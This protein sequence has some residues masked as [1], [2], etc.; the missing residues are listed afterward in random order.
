MGYQKGLYACA[1]FFPIFILCI[2]FAV[3]SVYPFGDRS[4]LVVDG[5]H[6]YMT[7]FIELLHQLKSGSSWTHA[8]HAMGYN[9][10]SVFC[11][12][13]SSPFTIIVLLLNQFL[14]INEALTIVILIKVGISGIAMTWYAGRTI[15]DH[16]GKVLCFGIMYALS[17]YVTGYYT[18]HMWMDAVMMLPFLA[19]AVEDLV[20]Q[21][22]W[23]KYAV[24]LAYCLIANYYMA[25]MVCIFIGLYFLCECAVNR[26]RKEIPGC[27][28]LFCLSTLLG[29]GISAVIL[30]PSA[31]AVLSSSAAQKIKSDVFQG[32][33]GTL[34]GQLGEMFFGAYSQIT[35]S[36]QDMVNVYCGSAVLFFLVLYFM[37]RSIRLREK[38][39]YGMLLVFYFAGF[40]VKIINL[41]L[42]GFHIPVGMP[43]RFA[44]LFIFLILKLS[45]TSW[46]KMKKCSIRMT[47]LAAAIAIFYVFGIKLINQEVDISVTL[48]VLGVI[49]I[50]ILLTQCGKRKYWKLGFSSMLCILILVEMGTHAVLSIYDHGTAGRSLWK[51][52]GEE[53]TYLRKEAEE[54]EGNPEK[55]RMIL[56]DLDLRN[57]ELLWQFNGGTL[58]SST[59]T[60]E[61]IRFMEKT[62]TETGENRYQYTG[63][64]ELMDMLLGVKYL[65]CPKAIHYHTR[66]E[67]VEETNL[68]FMYENPYALEN[69]YAVSDEIQ[70]FSLEGK[71]PFEVQEALLHALGYDDTLYETQ[72]VQCVGKTESKDEQKAILLDGLKTNLLDEK[73]DNPMKTIEI[74]LKAGEHGYLYIPGEEPET[75]RIDGRIQ[76]S[77]YWNNNFL[78]L[79]YAAEDRTIQIVA[80][81]YIPSAVL[82]TY[83]ETRL[84][85]IYHIL[86]EE[87]MTFSGGSGT[88]ELKEGKTLLIN[89]FYQEGMI[90][91]VDGKKAEVLDLA[92]LSGVQLTEGTHTVTV[93]YP[94]RGLWAG[95]IISVCS[96][97]T[98]LILI[99]VK[100]KRG[101]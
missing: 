47:L 39:V 73:K 43:N 10:Y 50:L 58:F 15:S 96:F 2:G 41:F 91:E 22:K 83:P 9:F 21:K 97:V 38:I 59:V 79:G 34:S 4:A 56:T 57:E 99:L 26:K 18:N 48:F 75:I 61:Q 71:N 45:V 69:A 63:T 80:D 93:R 31:Y 68:F 37:N 8:V 16:A 54:K 98:G 6:Q 27:I 82:G 87:Q 23:R 94:V 88:I 100:R 19:G 84:E 81:R 77:A 90:I 1:F 52:K 24:L 46:K 33:Y 5:T 17:N 11:Y 7:F 66:Y 101:M 86:S 92:G 67:K 62:G 49:L 72:T 36:G 70:K 29:A 14:Y 89:S 55:Y 60:D 28:R 53:L 78:D 76:Q 3:S 40:H 35:S 85:K 42:H 64:S 95:S 12:Y 30:I 65:V 44:F 13:L 20:N 74:T 32:T 25:F 51:E